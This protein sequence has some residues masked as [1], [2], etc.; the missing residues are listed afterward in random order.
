MLLVLLLSS[1]VVVTIKFWV[2]SC[3]NVSLVLIVTVLSDKDI[4]GKLVRSG[5]KDSVSVK[6]Q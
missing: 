2:V 1:T 5:A 6:K 4:Q 3:N